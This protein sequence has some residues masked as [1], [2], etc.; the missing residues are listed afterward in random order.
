MERLSS[1]VTP[2]FTSYYWHRGFLMLAPTFVLERQ[3]KP[4][5]RLSA[6]LMYAAGKP[7][8][9]ETGDGTVT[10]ARAVLIAPKVLRRRIVAV[11][12]DLMICDLSVATPH[13][14][15]VASLLGG[16]DVTVLDAACFAGLNDEIALAQKAELP[17]ERVP[18]LI[19]NLI[20]ALTGERPEALPLHPRIAQ[21][22][23]LIEESSLD[24][25][26]LPWLAEQ[27]H[28][29]PSRLRHLFTE[30]IGCS[31]T[32]YCRWSAV[33]KGVWLWSR[34]MSLLDVVVE[35]GFHDMA[36]INRAFNEVFG[37]NPSSLAN[38]DQIRLMRCPMI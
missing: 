20:F 7:F 25:V 2:V 14:N 30:Q 32:H 27:V 4:Y 16:D 23:A 33:W 6:T 12:S 31:L 10:E 1:P 34:G 8:V 38:A 24:A 18:A 35:T 26:S 19:D 37:L 13:F 3:D 28:L 17:V 15:A 21:V 5:R 36:H 29:S 11:D 9:I 22:L